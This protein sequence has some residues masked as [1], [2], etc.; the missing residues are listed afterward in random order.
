M[1]TDMLDI[2]TPHQPLKIPIVPS[3]TYL[4][5]VASYGSFE[6]RTCLHRQQ[7]AH[8]NRHRLVRVLHNRQL[9]LQHRVRLY[10][11]CFRSCLLYGQ[12]AVGFSH[13]VLRKHD[14]F[15]A[16]AV[17]LRGHLR[18]SLARRRSLCEHDCTWI[19]RMWYRRKHW[20]A[21]LPKSL[22]KLAGLGLVFGPVSCSTSTRFPS[23]L[24][25]VRL[26]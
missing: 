18:T 21:A 23:R 26:C 7:A 12:H 15:D 1:A 19:L 17:R 16:R 2:G 9:T 14:Q 6:L 5:V 8:A 13:N 3:M 10:V 20:I 24:L 25:T 22:M 4:G 11:A